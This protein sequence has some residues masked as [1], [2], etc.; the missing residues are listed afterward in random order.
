[1]TSFYQ[2]LCYG[3]STSHGNII[4]YIV[5]DSI[6]ITDNMISSPSRYIAWISV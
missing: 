1:M 6:I 2:A 4:Y 3:I 5:I